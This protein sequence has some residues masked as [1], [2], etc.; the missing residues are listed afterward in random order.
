[1]R[2]TFSEFVGELK[3]LHQTQ[4][5]LHRAAHRQVV[6]GDL[7]EDAVPV[8]DEQPSGENQQTTTTTTTTGT[9]N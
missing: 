3:C 8:D 6:D 1:V 9:G 7:P 5:L 4:G 2:P